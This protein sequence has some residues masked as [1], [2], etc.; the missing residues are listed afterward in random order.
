MIKDIQKRASG[1]KSQL[2]RTI[3]SLQSDI[4]T[5]KKDNDNVLNRV[6]I[7]NEKTLLEQ[8]DMYKNKLV[9]EYDK[10]DQIETAYNNM[11]ENN[12]KKTEELENSIEQRVMKIKTE[13]DSKLL[14]YE[15]EVKA[16][17]KQ[18]EEKIKAVEEILKQTEEDADK[19]IIELKTR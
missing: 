15:N 7:S 18:S 11:K 8:S 1:D 19:E 10:Y 12:K 16:R 14:Q 17:E 6:K 3:S 13:F 4:D 2:A 5:I 9:I